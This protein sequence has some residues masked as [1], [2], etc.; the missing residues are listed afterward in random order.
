[1]ICPVKKHRFFRICDGIIVI[2]SVAVPFV[3]FGVLISWKMQTPGIAY[4]NL[5]RSYEIVEKQP[6][7]MEAP[8][9]INSMGS[10]VYD[11]KLYSEDGRVIYQ[12][13]DLEINDFITSIAIPNS[14]T[15]GTY[16]FGGVLS[17]KMNPIKTAEVFVNFGTIVVTEETK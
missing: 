8:L 12:Y 15:P 7:R 4:I 9:A 14:L 3:L 10:S 11:L 2:L 1:M 13:E 5:N 16:Q 6:F 17:Y